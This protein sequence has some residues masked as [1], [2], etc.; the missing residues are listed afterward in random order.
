MAVTNPSSSGRDADITGGSAGVRSSASGDVGTSSS[1]SK[2][3]ESGTGSQ[4]QSGG[5]LGPNQALAL[6]AVTGEVGVKVCST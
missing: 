5:K 4:R 6:N 3:S 1:S 2:S